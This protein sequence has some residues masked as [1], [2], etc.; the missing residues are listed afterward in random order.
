MLAR[1]PHVLVFEPDP[2]G[3][4]RE[5]IGHILRAAAARPGEF[6]LT[7][8]VPAE[9]AEAVQPELSPRTRAVAL[10]PAE[11][12]R[13]NG[14]S[15]VAS[16]FARWATMRRYLRHLDATH[17]LF[18]GFD[19]LTLPFAC[20]LG[21]AGRRVSGILFRPT[22][23]YAALGSAPRDRREERRDRR[24]ALL[25]RR[26]LRNRAVDTV[27]SL[28][29]DFAAYAAARYE[30]GT[31][32]A[33]LPDP[34]HPPP[35]PTAEITAVTQ[36]IPDGRTVFLLFGEITE[37]K[38]PLP[39][40]KALAG[41]PAEVAESVA[42]VVA[43]RVDPEIAGAVDRHMLAVRWHRPELWLKVVDRWLDTGELGALVAR[44]DVILAPYQRFVGSSGVLLWAAR[45]R[46][47]VICQAYGLLG[48]MARRHGLGLT[49]DTGDP[50]ALAGAIARAVA[51]SPAALGDIE[52]MADFTA[53][54]TPEAFAGALLERCCRAP[55]GRA[56]PRSPAPE[57]A[58][59]AGV[60][61]RDSS[62]GSPG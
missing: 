8:V 12:R 10:S 52:A 1:P 62:Q 14:R 39:L 59:P 35:A 58:H 23:H 13:C 55:A 51:E 42:V 7:V 44:S 48:R 24:K 40:L 11:L 31:K 25:T 22:A 49:V 19:H 3:H 2:R 15:L 50:A 47:P 60:D 32:V 26:A 16:A 4:A 37:R 29:P 18:L 34:A 20:G 38:G 46:R 17:G 56:S 45:A 21:A 61:G 57:P 9:L 41:L 53:M 27:F 6:C 28:D 30:A 43:G 33:A 36:D 5:W 54:H